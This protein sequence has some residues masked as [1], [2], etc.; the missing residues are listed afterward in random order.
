MTHDTGLD[1]ILLQRIALADANRSLPGRF[2]TATRDTILASGAAIRRAGGSDPSVDW[3]M[4]WAYGFVIAHDVVAAHGPIHEA[5]PPPQP[6]AV[7][8]PDGHVSEHPER[9]APDCIPDCTEISRA[10]SPRR[11][12]SVV[13]GCRNV[14]V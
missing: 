10:R 11:G 3:L 7:P 4:G 8:H 6:R 1:E 14:C 13:P 9:I 2:D 5:H 12:V